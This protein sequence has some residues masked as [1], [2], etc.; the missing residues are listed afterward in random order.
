MYWGEVNDIF[1]VC[2]YRFVSVVVGVGRITEVFEGI[3]EEKFLK[4]FEKRNNYRELFKIEL[5]I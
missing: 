3:E 5:E 2:Y 1:V 4:L